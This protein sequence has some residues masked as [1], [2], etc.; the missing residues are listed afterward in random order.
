M[1]ELRAHSE[2]PT[3]WQLVLSHSLITQEVLDH[4]YD[5]SGTEDDPFVVEFIPDDPRNPMLFK[6]LK[7]W[8]IT[9]LIGVST[10]AVAFNSSA[11][12]GG[13]QQVIEEF[14]VSNEVV[15]L[16]VSLFVLGG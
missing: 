6:P 1:T 12:S 7:K 14:G 8:C 10:L 2:K 11:Y 9:V 4:K 3:N 13:V 5:G 15:T 16:G